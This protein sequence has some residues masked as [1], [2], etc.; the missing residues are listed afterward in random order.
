[1]KETER[2]RNRQKLYERRQIEK[3]KMADQ[4]DASAPRETKARTK[5]QNPV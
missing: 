5:T 1:M 3:K 4:D 2:E